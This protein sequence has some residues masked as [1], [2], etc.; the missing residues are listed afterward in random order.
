[1]EKSAASTI[2]D[3]EC[4]QQFMSCS[5]ISHNTSCPAALCSP[6]PCSPISRIVQAIYLWELRHSFLQDSSIR[7]RVRGK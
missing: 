1:M 4:V 7:V 5:P 3:G 6:M 2:A